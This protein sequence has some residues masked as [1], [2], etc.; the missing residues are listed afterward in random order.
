[1]TSAR[2]QPFCTKYD[3]NISCFE[4]M[5]K[6]PRNIS[7]GNISM[8]IDNHHFCLIWKSNT[9]SFDQAKAELILDF[10]VVDNVFCDKHVKSFVKKK[11]DPKKVPSPISKI[12]GYDL[13][14]YKKNRA[15]PYCSSKNKL[16]KI[17]GKYNGDITEKN[18]QKCFNDCIIY[19]G[20]DCINETLD[21]ILEFK[22]E[23]KKINNKIV[24]YNLYLIAQNGS[25][26]DS[27][28]V[29]KNLPQWRTVVSLIKNGAGVV[30]V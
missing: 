24:E 28:V 29:M 2:I 4:G 25:G 13:E 18:N 14:T 19:K 11:Y 30:S 16:C 21:H 7:Q 20:S 27:C 5:R 6:N 10:E 9:I 23:A 26:F 8:Y 12:F 22:R 1:M 17:S 15:V 3:I